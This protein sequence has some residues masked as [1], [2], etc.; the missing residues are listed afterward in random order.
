MCSRN[1]DD[2]YRNARPVAGTLHGRTPPRIGPGTY[3]TY[4]TYRGMINEEG[5]RRAH[6]Q[7]HTLASP[8]IHAQ[9]RMQLRKRAGS[10]WEYQRAGFEESGR[11]RRT[12][13]ESTLQEELLMQPLV[14]LRFIL[15]HWHFEHKSHRYITHTQVNG[16]NGGVTAASRYS[17][18]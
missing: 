3:A 14:L 1:L 2:K 8:C 10:T 17:P 9:L 13:A 12:A 7:L 16:A 18:S 15:S 4:A 5:R 6:A 11:L